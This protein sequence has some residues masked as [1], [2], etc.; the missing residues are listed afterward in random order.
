MKDVYRQ[1]CEQRQ[2]IPLFQQAWWLDATAGSDW[3]VVFVEKGGKVEAAL[4]FL[5][6]KRYGLTAISQPVLT[7]YLGPWLAPG[8]G[9]QAKLLA[10]EKGLMQALIE[11]LPPHHI[12]QQNWA[13][14]YKNWMPFFWRDFLQTTRYSYQLPDLN[15]L[16][17]IWGGFQDNIRREIRKAQK[18]GVTVSRSG[19]FEE[20]MSLNVKVFERQ[21]KSLPY[22]KGVVRN[23]EDAAAKRE[24]RAIFIATDESGRNHAAVYLVWDEHSA[25]Y[26]M[27]GGD[28]ALRSSGATSLCMWEAIQFASTVTQSFDFE[29]SMLEPVERFFRAFGGYPTPFFS[30]TR[31]QN[32]WLRMAMSIKGAL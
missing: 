3:D 22:S 11:Q 19:N 4:P 29:G 12:Y 25:Y 30:V 24:Q 32:R 15:D 23:I 2:D 18:L 14:K 6:K 28:P 9:K 5:L 1:L 16:D 17:A 13:P 8:K 10:R 7:Q 27:G 26:L 31:I 21:G 20:F